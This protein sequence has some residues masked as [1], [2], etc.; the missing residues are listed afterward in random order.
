MSAFTGRP[1]ALRAGVAVTALYLLVAGLAFATTHMGG[2]FWWPDASRHALN[3][4]FVLDFVKALPFDDPVGFAERYYVQYPALTVLFYPPL[5]YALM[6][7]PYALFGESHAVAQATIIVFFAGLLLVAHAI[8]RRYLPTAWAIAATLLFACAPQFLFWTRQVMVDT[9]A[10]FFLLFSTL[11]LLRYT[12]D[13]QP[14]WIWWSCASFVAAI[15]CKYNVAFAAPAL[16]AAL[17]AAGGLRTLARR[18]VLAAVAVSAIALVPAMMLMLWFGRENISSVQGGLRNDLPASD[19]RAWLVYAR[20]LPEQLGTA[21]LIALVLGWIGLA[22]GRLRGLAQRDLWLWLTWLVVGYLLFSYIKVREP[23]H[24]LAV[25]FPFVLL[26]TAGLRQVF[27]R[28]TPAAGWLAA[29]AAAGYTAW[30]AVVVPAPFV[31]GYARAA[32]VVGERGAPAD[33]VLFHGYRD[34][35]FVYD[36]RVNPATR[37]MTTI[38]SDKLI[39]RVSIERTR[40]IS[41]K[42]LDQAAMRDLF[43]TLS[44]R[45]V[46]VQPGFWSDLPYFRDF[47]TVLGDRSLFEPLARVPVR[48]NQPVPEQE[49]LVYRYIGPVVENPASIAIEISPIGRKVER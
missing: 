10:V 29:I 23:R 7:V 32:A 20:F 26:G 5:T 22:A 44:I 43:R 6:A 41:G 45:W 24:T 34:G 17:I 4:L 39:A 21:A 47:E 38:R 13:W 8:A 48:S 42:G 36:M 33:R 11:A 27:D 46:V 19:I 15:Y 49:L 16:L 40:G 1:G 2:D 31:E 3:G 37:A 9:P 35:T 12:D 14:R 18:E 30:L 28:L 25:L